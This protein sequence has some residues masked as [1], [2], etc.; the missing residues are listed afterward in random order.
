MHKHLAKV[1]D[2]KRDGVTLMPQSLPELECDRALKEKQTTERYVKGVKA[3]LRNT[4]KF[5]PMVASVSDRTCAKC[6][7]RCLSLSDN[8]M[9]AVVEALPPK[10]IELGD[11]QVGLESMD[12]SYN[13]VTD[14]G[15]EGVRTAGALFC[16]R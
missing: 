15:V 1:A 14:A 13:E 16:L 10:N 4:D 3:N 11:G 2:A 5:A 9:Q 12:L 6:D 8:D 7:L